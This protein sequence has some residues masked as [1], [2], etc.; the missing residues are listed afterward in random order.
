MYEKKSTI[1]KY[2]NKRAPFRVAFS[3]GGDNFFENF[4]L[5]DHIPHNDAYTNTNQNG[6]RVKTEENNKHSNLFFF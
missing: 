3:Y 1:Q 6:G 4:V 5:L 2:V